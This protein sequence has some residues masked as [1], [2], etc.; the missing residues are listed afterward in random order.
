MKKTDELLSRFGLLAPARAVRRAALGAAYTALHSVRETLTRMP[1]PRFVIADGKALDSSYRA[2]LEEL[3]RDGITRLSGQFSRETLAELQQAFEKFISQLDAKGAASFACVSDPALAAETYDPD[4]RQY[5]SLEPFAMSRALLEVCLKPQLVSLISS[6]LGKAPYITQGIAMRIK[7]HS[8]SGFNSF[9]WHHD[10]WGKR[11]KLMIILT[12]VGAGDQ[13]MTYAKGSHRL[14]HSYAKYVNSRYSREEFAERCGN[15]QVLDCHAMPGDIYIFD[16][17]GV[18]SGNRTN[19]RTRD[20]FTVAYTRMAHTIW[21]HH[22]PAEFLAGFSEQHLEPLQWI[23]RQDR[24][25]RS[26]APPVNSWVAQL[27]RVHKWLL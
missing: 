16:T 19:G 2:H 15:T 17:N 14:R 11:I 6:Y 7:P 20:T 25:K 12:E 5:S 10:A 4:A 3:R 26:L 1:D 13:F 24:G 22:I 9:Q 18:H 27:P 23:L 21:A 8:K